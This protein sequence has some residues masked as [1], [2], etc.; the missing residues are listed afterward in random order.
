[1]KKKLLNNQQIIAD[2]LEDNISSADMKK[3]NRGT[4]ADER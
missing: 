1:L 3:G 4:S 2:R